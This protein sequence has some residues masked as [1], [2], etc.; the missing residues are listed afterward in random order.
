M[1]GGALLDHNS[2]GDDDDDNDED[3]DK[4]DDDKEGDDDHSRQDC[5][6]G[7]WALRQGTSTITMTP[8]RWRSQ[9]GLRRRQQHQ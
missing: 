8:M 4:D 5:A 9:V 1:R 7:M 2:D 6:T 3:E